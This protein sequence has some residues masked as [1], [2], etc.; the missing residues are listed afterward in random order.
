MRELDAF[1][2]ARRIHGVLASES[3]HVGLSTVYRNL[4]ALAE[5]GVL[6]VVRAADGELL[7]RQCVKRSH[8]HLICRCCGRAVELPDGVVRRLVMQCAASAGYRRVEPVLEV[9]GTCPQCVE[10]TPK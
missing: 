8:H 2:S 4:Q 7:F 9:F 10:S 1:A 5:R 3:D 6:D